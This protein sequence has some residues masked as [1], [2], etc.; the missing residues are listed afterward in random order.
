[1]PLQRNKRGL[2]TLYDQESDP[3]FKEVEMNSCSAAEC[4]R[5]QAKLE[6]DRYLTEPQMQELLRAEQVADEVAKQ[7][8]RAPAKKAADTA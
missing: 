5:I 4:L 8:K 7:T 3:R 6:K 1:M 2:V